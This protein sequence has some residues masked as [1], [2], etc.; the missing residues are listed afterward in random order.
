MSRLAIIA[1][2]SFNRV[3]GKDG[4]LPWHIPEELNYFRR[5]TKGKVLIMGRKTYESIPK[6]LKERLTIVITSKADDIDFTTGTILKKKDGLDDNVVFARDPEHA[7]ALA[8]NISKDEIM[9]AGG[10][11]I[12]RYFID[13]VDKIY[14][15]VIEAKYEGD[16]YFPEIPK[17]F[18]ENVIPIRVLK[19]P[20]APGV[21]FRVFERKC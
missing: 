5:V 7:L 20:E 18:N 2:M 1:A 16:A 4:K 12:Y 21:S 15:S 17:D 19:T 13:K 11:S 9:I 14:L 6:K 3:I 10:E 8:L